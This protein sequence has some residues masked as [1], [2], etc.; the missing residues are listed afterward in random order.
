VRG[1][2]GLKHGGGGGPKTGQSQ[3]TM[4]SEVCVV[5]KQKFKAQ[6]G[7]QGPLGWPC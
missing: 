5:G 3:E 6:E 1:S 7:C 4:P 2:Q